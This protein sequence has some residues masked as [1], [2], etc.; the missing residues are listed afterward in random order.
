MKSWK[1]NLLI[2]VIISKL[3]ARVKNRNYENFGVVSLIGVFI[4][5][6]G[7]PTVNDLVT[8]KIDF[9]KFFV[10]YEGPHATPLMNDKF[11][12]LA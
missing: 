1:E 4:V 5:H 2:F 11:K 12:I 8:N 10:F 3:A 6:M 9:S 7:I